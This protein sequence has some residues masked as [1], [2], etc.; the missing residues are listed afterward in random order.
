[1]SLDDLA[2]LLVGGIAEVVKLKESVDVPENLWV[3][4]IVDAPV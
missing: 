2:V 3:Y 1:M 4:V